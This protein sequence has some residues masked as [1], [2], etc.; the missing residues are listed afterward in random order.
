MRA[1]ASDLGASTGGRQVKLLEDLGGFE[2]IGVLPRQGAYYP[3][4]QFLICEVGEPQSYL[5]RCLYGLMGTAL[6]I[7]QPLPSLSSAV[8]V[9]R[10][11]KSPDPAAANAWG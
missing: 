10:A 7:Q 9:P 11:D 6:D 8:V 3:L 2:E 1:G 4:P 5:L